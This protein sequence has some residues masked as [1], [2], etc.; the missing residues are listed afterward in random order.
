MEDFVSVSS[1]NVN[2]KVYE[3]FAVF[4]G[5][6]GKDART[7]IKKGGKQRQ[8]FSLF[9][10]QINNLFLKGD[11]IA[12]ECVSYLPKIIKKNLK[13][14]NTDIKGLLTKSFEEADKGNER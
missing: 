9:C 8:R 4:D 3:L 11:Q 2:G 13:I 1:F 5:H 10:L 14:N 7:G 6:G 12:K